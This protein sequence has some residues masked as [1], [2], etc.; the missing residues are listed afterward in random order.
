MKNLDKSALR[1]TFLLYVATA[2]PPASPRAT[3]R[4]TGRYCDDAP[5]IR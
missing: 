2:K 4:I 3:A 5:T 1:V